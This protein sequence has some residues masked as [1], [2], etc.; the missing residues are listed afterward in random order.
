MSTA[1]TCTARLAP[2]TGDLPG[3]AGAVR[4]V[5][6]SVPR[7]LLGAPRPDPPEGR[8]IRAGD[9]PRPRWGQPPPPVGA[10][11][12]YGVRIRRRVAAAA[13]AEVR[14]STPSFA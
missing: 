6:C 7:M 4:R 13:T 11:R 14:E 12:S 10:G 5:G 8:W 1:A 9:S 2:K 3:G